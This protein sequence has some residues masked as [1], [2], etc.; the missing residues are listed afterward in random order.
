[1]KKLDYF[2][3]VIYIVISIGFAFFLIIPNGEYNKKY[4]EIKIDNKEYMKIDLP[5]KTKKTIVVDNKYGKNVIVIENDSVQ[6]IEADCF[7]QIDV[8][9]GK[10]DKVGDIIACLPHKLIIEIKGEKRNNEVDDVSY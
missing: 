2:L 7:N 5:Q 9:E 1:M 6:V 4:V 3:I 8:L 10:K